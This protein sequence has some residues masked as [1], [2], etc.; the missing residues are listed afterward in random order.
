MTRD[1]A[2]KRAKTMRE[3]QAKQAKIAQDWRVPHNLRY[4]AVIKAEEYDE[5]AR[6]FDRFAERPLTSGKAR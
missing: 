5:A 2:I 6:R 3:A 4:E 1:H